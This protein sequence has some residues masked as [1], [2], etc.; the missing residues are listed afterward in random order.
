MFFM[1]SLTTLIGSIGLTAAILF[2][3]GCYVGY[4]F[5]HDRGKVALAKSVDKARQTEQNLHDDYG[6]LNDLKDEEVRR[7]A[8]ERDRALIGLRDRPGRL[9]NPAAPACL[10]SSGAVLS[11]GDSE[12]LTRQAARADELRTQLGACQAREWKAYEALSGKA[13]HLD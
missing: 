4:S 8:A 1:P 9:P 11:R 2:P 6:V 12:F 3:V 7:I 13:G 10:G 5:E